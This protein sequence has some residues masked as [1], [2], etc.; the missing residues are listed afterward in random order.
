MRL[1]TALMSQVGALQPADLA[2]MLWGFAR[3]QHHPGP[4]LAAAAAEVREQLPAYPP[5]LLRWLVWSFQQFA[6]LD[7]FGHFKDEGLMRALSRQ[8]AIQ[9][10]EQH[11]QSSDCTR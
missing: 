1:N 6:V 8:V 10:A 3:L 11:S 4:W 7:V 2:R 5:S 9:K